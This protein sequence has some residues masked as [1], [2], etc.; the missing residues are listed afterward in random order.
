MKERKEGRREE[1][2]EGGGRMG[3]GKE[4]PTPPFVLGWLGV[5]L[6][7]G[8]KKQETERDREASLGYRGDIHS[9]GQSVLFP[10]R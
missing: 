6:S 1:G 2:K 8:T 4:E 5:P 3:G 9:S 7:R 10:S